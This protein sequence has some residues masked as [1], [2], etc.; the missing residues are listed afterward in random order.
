MTL[1]KTALF[2]NLPG[3]ILLTIAEESETRE[4]VEGQKIF[5]QGDYP[6]GLYTVASGKVIIKRDG[7]VIS[8]LKEYGFFGEIGILDDSPRGGDA[9]AETDA[10][11]LFIEKEV[12]NS[13]TEDL[14]EV[15]RAVTKTVIGYLKKEERKGIISNGS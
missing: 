6:D 13:I 15:L 9:I 1:R 12:F 3:E 2:E 4:L 11:L 7:H 10:T 14:P 8:E 5:S